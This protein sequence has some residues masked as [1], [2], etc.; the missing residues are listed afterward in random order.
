MFVAD[1]QV[2]I[3]IQTKQC[4]SPFP[5]SPHTTVQWQCHY[6]FVSVFPVDIMD[7]SYVFVLLLFFY[8]GGRGR[9]T[10]VTAHRFDCLTYTMLMISPF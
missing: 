10:I 6:V 5:A 8:S 3:S 9:G 1:I 4:P 7:F 2:A